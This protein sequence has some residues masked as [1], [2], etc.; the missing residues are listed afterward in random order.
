MA[1]VAK[2]IGKAIGTPPVRILT[3]INLKIDDGEFVALTGRS[4]SGKSTL[5]YILS[6]LDSPSEGSVEVAG[7]DLGKMADP[8]LYKFRNEKMGF[9]FQFHYLI[10]ELT[11]IEN[12][13]LPAVKN[14]RQ[15]ERRAYAESLLEQFGLGDKIHRLPRQ[16]SGG[17]QQRLAIARALVMQPKYL[18]ADEPTGSLDSAN[19]DIVMNIIRD[20]NKNFGTTVI[21][22]THDP[23]FAA[24][25]NR[26]INLVDGR[27]S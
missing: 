1:I 25:A 22:V 17:E 24:T 19:G 10:S 7:H 11:A 6:S 8:E 23:D 13:L 5:L 12:V 14:R 20:A 16:L 27:I 2:K 3:D 21:M 15:I 9:V 4:G 18:F 26:A